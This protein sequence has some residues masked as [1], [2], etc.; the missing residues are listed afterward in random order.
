MKIS[1]AI[2][3]GAGVYIGWEIAKLIDKCLDRKFK[4]SKIGQDV[5]SRY[6]KNETPK[7]DAT[8]NSIIG[9]HME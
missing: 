8:E 1:E 3:L 9:F 4:E 7:K 2:K 6:Q 5:I